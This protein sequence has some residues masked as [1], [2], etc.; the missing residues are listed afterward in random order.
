MD[1]DLH[2]FLVRMRPVPLPDEALRLPRPEKGLDITDE[3]KDWLFPREDVLLD[4]LDVVE[5]AE[6]REGMEAR[7]F[8]R[9][10]TGM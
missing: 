6:V 3:R 5:A 4:T 8:W 10:L 7:R 9:A 2:S 1:L